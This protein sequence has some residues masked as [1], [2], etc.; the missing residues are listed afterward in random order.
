MRGSTSQGAESADIQRSWLWP[1]TGRSASHL[2]DYKLVRFMHAQ[3]THC[4]AGKKSNVN[5]HSHAKISLVLKL[6]TV[7]KDTKFAKANQKKS[8]GLLWQVWIDLFVAT[9]L[10]GVINPPHSTENG[11][12]KEASKGKVAKAKA[13]QKSELA[14]SRQP[15]YEQ[16]I[17][18]VRRKNM[19]TRRKEKKVS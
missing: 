11:H 5:S 10:I 14:T 6:L 15:R 19:E 3:H 1:V 2:S 9:N 8:Y 7:S 12:F 18:T 17:K 16:K 4:R 13:I